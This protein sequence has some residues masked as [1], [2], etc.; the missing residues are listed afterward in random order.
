MSAKAKSLTMPTKN[1]DIQEMIKSN[2]KHITQSNRKLEVAYNH[3]HLFLLKM[4][5]VAPKIMH[6][7]V[8]KT[9]IN[10]LSW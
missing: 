1:F 2:H 10:L 3:Q 8:L 6:E 5:R 4:G 9:V 7:T